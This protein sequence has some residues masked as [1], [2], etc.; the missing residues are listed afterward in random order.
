MGRVIAVTIL[1]ALVV[2]AAIPPVVGMFLESNIRAELQIPEPN[3]YIEY[4]LT[5]YDRGLYSSDG[6]M[7]V[8][9]T[10]EYAN[11]IRA[12]MAGAAMDDP[13]FRSDL[14]EFLQGEMQVDFDVHHGPFLVRR[15][16]LG[17]A[18]FNSELMPP[19]GELAKFVA[20]NDLPYLLRARGTFDFGD[21][22]TFHYDIPPVSNENEE[23]AYSF[24]GFDAHGVLDL[25]SMRLKA[26]GGSERLR[27][28]GD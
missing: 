16:G 12:Q 17:I 2:L 5:D 9:L 20:D 6:V 10:E 13:D 22:L 1:V 28:L 7:A 4:R 24:T 19:D 14:E 15:P 26:E 18:G 27:M 3:P 11:S 8:R 25:Q 21:T 23:L